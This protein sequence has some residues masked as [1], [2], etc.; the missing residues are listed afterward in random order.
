MTPPSC[1]GLPETCGPDGNESCCA[2]AEAVPG[3]TFSRGNDTRYPATVSGLLLERFEVTVG[4]FRQFVE[5]YPGSNPAVGAGAHSW[6]NGSGWVADWDGT[7]PADAAALKT[8]VKCH[9]DYQ[10]WTDEA[11]DHENLPIN[12]SWYVAFAFC[13]WDGGRLATEA[14]W[15]YAAAGGAEQRQ[16]PWSS[17]ASSTTID[18]SYA[19]YDCAGD[20]SAPEWCAV[21]GIQP[22]GSRSQKGDGKWG[23]ADLAGN[24]WEW[25]LDWDD[26]YQVPC[27]NCAN[28]NPVSRR[29]CRGGSWNNTAGFMASSYRGETAPTDRSRDIGIRC[30]RTP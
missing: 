8:A 15:N 1:V 5:A 16:Y 9:S 14:E 21:R 6:I 24:V 13:A 18:A 3:G 19:V 22:V 2:T 25:V 27:D 23:Q 11:A 29:V 30:A 10:T 26:D 7:L 17:S 4:R 12:W 28:L 20:V